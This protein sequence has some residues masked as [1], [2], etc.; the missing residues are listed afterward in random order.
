MIVSL[1]IVVVLYS[2]VLIR[3]KQASYFSCVVF[4]SIVVNHIQDANPYVF[5]WNRFLDTIIGIIVGVVVNCFTIPGK[6]NK[7]ILF[8]SGL[9]DTL[10][11]KNGSVSDYSRIE[12]NLMIE[13]GLN[14][15]VSTMRTPASLMEPLRGINLKLPV[16]AMDGAALYNIIEN[17]YEHVYIISAEHCDKILDYFEGKQLPYLKKQLRIEKTVTFG[18][19]EGKYT[20]LIKPGDFNRVVKLVKRQFFW[21]L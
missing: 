5:V 9:D 18:T 6:K 10:L 19:I 15:T 12:L 17:R 13:N 21:K 8:L 1:F 2:T 16:I 3:Q 7:D 4:L 14:F 11:A 20:Y